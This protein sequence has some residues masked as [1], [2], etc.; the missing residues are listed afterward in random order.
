MKTQAR[1]MGAFES[2]V[3]TEALQ[4]V[5]WAGEAMGRLTSPEV[6]EKWRGED[7]TRTISRTSL[8]SALAHP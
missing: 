4:K 8:L 1:E 6:A 7:G 2:A 3:R 5:P